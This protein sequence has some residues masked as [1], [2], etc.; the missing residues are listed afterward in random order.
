MQKNIYIAIFIIITIGVGYFI[1]Y[2][3]GDGQ[4]SDISQPKDNHYDIPNL[5]ELKAKTADWD[6]YEDEEYGI[7]VRYPLGWSYESP[8]DVF[9]GGPQITSYNAPM[10]FSTNKQMEGIEGA[11]TMSGLGGG[12]SISIFYSEDLSKIPTEE[13]MSQYYEE[14]KFK[15]IETFSINGFEGVIATREY[16]AK[17]REEAGLEGALRIQQGLVFRKF[18]ER[19]YYVQ[20]GLY[21][22]YAYSKFDYSDISYQNQFFPF[23]ATFMSLEEEKK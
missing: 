10:I 9:R 5:E 1:Y 13:S 2:N 4:R 18:N 20:W 23:L 6:V 14:K 19:V 7:K 15:E 3:K 16:S 17:E 12:T 22:E 11:K 8:P 21:E